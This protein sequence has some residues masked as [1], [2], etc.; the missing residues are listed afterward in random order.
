MGRSDI[1]SRKPCNITSFHLLCKTMRHV[2]IA[3]ALDMLLSQS[4]DVYL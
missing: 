4:E 2:A 1:I 3:E